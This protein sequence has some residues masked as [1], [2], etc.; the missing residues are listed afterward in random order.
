MIVT[1]KSGHHHVH[2]ILSPKVDILSMATASIL[3]SSE[4]E[5]N[6]VV[7]EQETAIDTAKSVDAGP[8]PKP[9]HRVQI[10][11]DQPSESEAKRNREEIKNNIRMRG[12]VLIQNPSMEWKVR[13]CELN[14]SFLTFFR[15]QKMVAAIDLEQVGDINV[16]R[17]IKDISGQGFIFSLHLKEGRYF[18]VRVSMYEDAMNWVGVLVDVRDKLRSA[19]SFRSKSFSTQNDGLPNM[20]PM[21]ADF[22]TSIIADEPD[23]NIK[24]Y[25]DSEQCPPS[26]ILQSNEKYIRPLQIK[27]PSPEKH[28]SN[29]SV[30]S[31]GSSG[32]TAAR[33]R[34]TG[35]PALSSRRGSSV[36]NLTTELSDA[37]AVM[38]AEVRKGVDTSP[39]R[40]PF[41]AVA[42][43]S[44]GGKESDR[45]IPRSFNSL[46]GEF[47]Q[48]G[49]ELGETVSGVQDQT[50]ID[51]GVEDEVAGGAISA[52]VTPQK[53]SQAPARNTTTTTNPTTAPTS[54]TTAA[55]DKTTASKVVPNNN[56]LDSNEM[57]RSFE[58]TREQYQIAERAAIESAREKR[59]E[60]EKAK[61]IAAEKAAAELLAVQEKLKAQKATREAKEIEE[62]NAREK[63]ILAERKEKEARLAV[64]KL[65][66]EER[67]ASEKAAKE[68]WMAA[69]RAARLEKAALERQMKEKLAAEKAVEEAKLQAI[70]AREEEKVQQERAQRIAIREAAAKKKLAEDAAAQ[71]EVERR[72]RLKVEE[73]AQRRTRHRAI[74]AAERQGVKLD[75]AVLTQLQ[76]TPPHEVHTLLAA[77]QRE[78]SWINRSRSTSFSMDQRDGN[79][80]SGVEGVTM[81]D[82]PRSSFSSSYSPS[83]HSNSQSKSSPVKSAQ[84]VA[85]SVV[86]ATASV[87][88]DARPPPSSPAGLRYPLRKAD[89]TPADPKVAFYNADGSFR[90]VPNSPATTKKRSS[91]NS[92]RLQQQSPGSA[93]RASGTGGSSSDQHSGASMAASSVPGQFP[94]LSMQNL[95]THTNK[96]A[97]SNVSASTPPGTLLPA[98]TVNAEVH[99]VILE[100][101]EEVSAVA[102]EA[103]LERPMKTE[104]TPQHRAPSPSYTPVGGGSGRSPAR[105]GSPHM[106]SNRSISNPSPSATKRA[107]AVKAANPQSSSVFL[108]LCVT[109]S[110]VVLVLALLGGTQYY[111]RQMAEE[112]WR[113]ES[114]K[115]LQAINQN[116]LS[117]EDLSSASNTVLTPSVPLQRETT[118]TYKSNPKHSRYTETSS[119]SNHDIDS[120][121][122]V[123][124]TAIVATT[125]SNSQRDAH[126]YAVVRSNNIM[127]RFF[128]NI[129]RASARFVANVFTKFT[130]LFRS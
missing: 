97:V 43:A 54:T 57:D 56:E 1:T 75:S 85:P 49:C 77:S 101:I 68:A 65:A 119:T 64:E 36:S 42:A 108:L 4:M 82:S 27:V 112:Q 117:A 21:T 32:N 129:F 48:T 90:A 87:T 60:A 114:L 78:N 39:W 47:V 6:D 22:N 98:R 25:F 15:K 23:D 46:E 73:S 28:S 80:L 109:M 67:L 9:K 74:V 51:D 2:I 113:S 31:N 63:R 17:Q 93:L 104:S 86:S 92:T 34:P 110:V 26:P 50:L 81:V 122:S 41:N 72:E 18:N 120:K 35:I 59:I 44:P 96:T 52:P 111:N 126:T 62:K 66:E 94:S 53:P 121:S 12:N 88:S 5:E 106:Q 11:V 83:T 102:S 38:A 123:R 16:L 3:F 33:S 10:N 13:T 7:V 95:A 30:G 130:R 125:H 105:S 116:I 76:S 20:T 71:E 107:A 124:V 91:P 37:E 61:R 128:S 115:H 69:E 118:P 55:P 70:K 103:S 84:V 58:E 8:E 24:V 89:T 14:G 19:H 127:K 40:V 45:P 29:S 79:L 100:V 99:P